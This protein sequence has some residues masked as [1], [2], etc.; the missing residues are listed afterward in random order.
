MSNLTNEKK[1]LAWGGRKG[2]V[3]LRVVIVEEEEL[4]LSLSLVCGVFAI[5]KQRK[6][7]LW[8]GRNCPPLK[9]F[10]VHPARLC[11]GS[12]ALFCSLQA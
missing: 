12:G 9:R 2:L 3:G 6:P 1:M 4:C 7:D 8:G 10:H 5:G 11:Q